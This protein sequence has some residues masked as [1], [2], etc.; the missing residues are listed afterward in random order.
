MKAN[1]DSIRVPL[2]GGGGGVGAAWRLREEIDE[3]QEGETMARKDR[4]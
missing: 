3:G 2:G 4:Y 1:F